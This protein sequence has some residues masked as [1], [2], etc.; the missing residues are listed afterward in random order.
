M[1]QKLMEWIRRSMGL[2]FKDTGPGALFSVSADMEAEILKWSKMYEN[3]GQK[4]SIGLPAA[5]ASE[6]ARMVVMECEISITGSK[7]A[8]YIMEQFARI[9]LQNV[10]EPAC[11]LGGVSL[12]P[13]VSGKNIMVDTVEADCFLPTAFDSSKR[14]SGV[15][16]ADQ[17]V[18]EKQIFTRLEK[19]DFVNNTHRV[20]NIAFVSGNNETLGKQISLEAVPEW[21]DLAPAMEIPG[22][23]V[24]LFAYF[25]MPFKNTV[26]RR[27]PLGISAFS[28]AERLIN[29][30]NEQYGRYLW[31]FE[32]G[33]LAVDVAENHIR[34]GPDG[35]LNLP[36]HERRLYR[37]H[38]TQ[39]NFYKIFAPT[40]RD[41]SMKRGFNT[42]LQRIEFNCGLSYGTLSDPQ[43]IEKTAEEIRNSKNRSYS[44]VGSIQKA[45]QKALTNL[46]YAMDKLATMYDLAPAGEY[47][48]A[49]D[50][51][52]SIVN[53]PAERRKRFWQYVQA[54]KY[55]F[56]RYLMEFEG[57]TEDEAKAIQAESSQA[58]GD[59]YAET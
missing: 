12:K 4:H 50:W 2:Y 23:E 32:G 22:C 53:D 28:R 5:I 38:D 1:F 42:I 10:V 8:D 26:D 6:L 30:A 51:D 34:H 16:F 44:T 31:E 37:M 35:V 24:P 52:D 14:M 45:A 55:P 11:A 3:Q 36:K 47:K 40:L 39:E 46:I 13:Y 57:Y 33:E 18:R 58:M 54:G 9:D 15:V 43:T 7:R 27:S 49:F 25:K 59:P 29:D 21:A 17:I 19:H 41:E 20:Q 48:I 56:W